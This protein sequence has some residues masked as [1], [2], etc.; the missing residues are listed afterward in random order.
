MILSIFSVIGTTYGGDGVSTFNVPDLREAVPVGVGSSN[1][2]AYQHDVYTLGPFKDDQNKSH[3][4]NVYVKDTGHSHALN[5]PYNG[6]FSGCGQSVAYAPV[7]PG[8]GLVTLSVVSDKAVIVVND[9]GTDTP[10]NITA[11]S[12]GDVARGNRLGMNYTIKY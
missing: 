8:N 7:A 1:R 3:A 4:H 10:K 12:G 11:N 2:A 6:V 9:D 5:Y